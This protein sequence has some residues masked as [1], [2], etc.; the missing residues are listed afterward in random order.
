MIETEWLA[1]EPAPLSHARER[2]GVRGSGG[3]VSGEEA[4]RKSLSILAVRRTHLCSHVS[5]LRQ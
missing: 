3:K 2:R 4:P 5:L 1:R